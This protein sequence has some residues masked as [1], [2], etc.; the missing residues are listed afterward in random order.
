MNTPS[1]TRSGTRSRAAIIL[2]TAILALPAHHALAAT[3]Y[4][5]TS[6]PTPGLGG[7]GTWE[8]GGASA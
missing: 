5:D 1:V 8:N 7:T 6:L 2:L 3:F 4:W